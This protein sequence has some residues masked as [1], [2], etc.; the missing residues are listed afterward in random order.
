MHQF[1]PFKDLI[2]RSGI[3]ERD[4]AQRTGLSRGA[5]RAILG[6]SSGNPTL[7]SIKTLA[8]YFKIQ[9]SL[10]SAPDESSRSDI[11][12]ISAS[13]KVL[14]DGFDSW[15]IHFMD[16]VDYF[17]SSL[18]TECLLLPPC[19]M[20]DKRLYALMS[21]IV[22]QLCLES[23]VPPP[24]WSQQPCFLEKP[25]FLAGMNSLKAS[26]LVESPVAFRSNNIFVLDNFLARK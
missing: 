21:S 15:K 6:S 19:K 5:I 11:S 12:V 18:D 1:V 13:Q 7:K 14:Q 25:W 10:S 20:L 16:L 2:R 4:L 8:D 9:L 26:A 17:R 23:S 22:R 3:S 24:R